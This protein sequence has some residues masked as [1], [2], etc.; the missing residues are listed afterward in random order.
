[1]KNASQRLGTGFDLK[2][3]SAGN[4]TR[5]K[6]EAICD[7]AGEQNYGKRLTE[8]VSSG[9]VCNRGQ[10]Q[11]SWSNDSALDKADDRLRQQ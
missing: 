5:D 7:V 9:A 3:M 1:M 2:R 6:H 10:R 4:K 11:L 8:I